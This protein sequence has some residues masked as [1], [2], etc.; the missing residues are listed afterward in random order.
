MLQKLFSSK[1]RIEVLSLFFLHSGRDFYLR[2]ITRLTGEDYKS[3]SMELKK[4][5]EIGLLNS[6]KNGNLKYF[7]LNGNFIIYDELKSIFLKT[8]GAAQIL[9][10]A[11]LTAQNIDYAFIYG[12]LASGT[13]RENSDID[14]MII[15]AIP[16]EEILRIVRDPEEKLHREISVSLYEISEIQLRLKNRDPFITQVMS[17][18]KIMLTGDEDDL[19]RLIEE[20]SD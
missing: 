20:G 7:Q 19:R 15:G 12:S 2:E 5:E 14:L 18:H 11:L 1:V 13:N 10:D 8:H 4:L 3:I 9:R 6:R 17:E 16:L